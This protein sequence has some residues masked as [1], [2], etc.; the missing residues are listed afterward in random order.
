MYISMNNSIGKLLAVSALIGTILLTLLGGLALV[1][2]S[3]RR[4]NLTL[5]LD[6]NKNSK[7][8]NS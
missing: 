5:L 6:L 2:H 4:V 3:L 8:D 7:R 1:I